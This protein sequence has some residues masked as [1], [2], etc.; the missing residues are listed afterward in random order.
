MCVFLCPSLHNENAQIIDGLS[1]NGI[2]VSFLDVR[3]DNYTKAIKAHT[4]RVNEGNIDRSAECRSFLC[5]SFE[6]SRRGI[7][8]ARDAGMC[9]I[10]IASNRIEYDR[11]CSEGAHAVALSVAG[12]LENFHVR[13][14][15]QVQYLP[16]A[17]H[18]WHLAEQKVGYPASMLDTVSGRFM[19]PT[20]Q[21]VGKDLFELDPHGQRV[22]PREIL[23]VSPNSLAD[24][25]INNVGWPQD[26]IG[27]FHLETHEL[28]MDI[29]RMFGRFYGCPEGFLQ[30]FVTSSGTEGS[31]SGLWWNRDFVQNGGHSPI[32]LTS[33]QTR[34][35][36][37]I[38]QRSS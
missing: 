23:G 37:S 20:S 8:A 11:L 24:V 10:G 25:Y 7:R 3:K 16:Y 15:Y 29:I 31:F 21:M 4:V 14:Y 27:N 35:S 9:A 26:N 2:V 36:V 18:L 19:K 1:K 13:N 12:L 5:L 33:N 34:Y 22:I 6:D 38:R 32:L 28:E 17:I 30:G